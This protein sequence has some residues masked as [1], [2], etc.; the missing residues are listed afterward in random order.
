M[1]SKK[2]S[3][4]I[5]S[6]PHKIVCSD[7]Q[8]IIFFVMLFHLWWST[9]RL[10]ISQKNRIRSNIFC[11]I[12][13]LRSAQ[14][15]R[16]CATSLILSALHF[17]SPH[18]FSAQYISSCMSSSVKT[19]LHVSS[20]HQ[21]PGIHGYFQAKNSKH[22]IKQN[23]MIKHTHAHD[24]HLPSTQ[25]LLCNCHIRHMDG[26]CIQTTRGTNQTHN[27]EMSNLESRPQL[28]K[29]NHNV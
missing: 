21:V 22:K 27:S 25:M 9:I 15:G 2:I 28:L 17:H 7:I 18:M 19:I 10:K 8:F 13:F 1:L 11:Y 20:H 4:T 12:S 23:N 5:E 24:P 29:G 3:S 26:P 16:T 6:E 14:P